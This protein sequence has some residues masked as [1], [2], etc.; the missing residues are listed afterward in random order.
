[1]VWS[2][3]LVT[4]DSL[5]WWAWLTST[6]PKVW[7]QAIL[8]SLQ[9]HLFWT[10]YVQISKSLSMF[11]IG[12]EYHLLWCDHVCENVFRCELK[13]PKILSDVSQYLVSYTPFV[14]QSHVTI[15]CWG[16]WLTRS[17]AKVAMTDHIGVQYRLL[18][19]VS[20]NAFRFKLNLAKASQLVEYWC[21]IYMFRYRQKCFLSSCMLDSSLPLKECNS[22]A[23]SWIM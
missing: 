2:C 12:A 4:Y 7:W 5:F 9:Y 3:G 14:D 20:K 13:F 6:K 15:P 18:W 22:Y 23:L 16:A 11:N 17:N 21:P 19:S 10:Y 1:M 8:N